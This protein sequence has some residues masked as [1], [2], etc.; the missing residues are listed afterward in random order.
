MKWQDF[1]RQAEAYFLKTGR[2][3]FKGFIAWAKKQDTNKNP[4]RYDDNGPES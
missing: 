1:I 4:H 2:T 3:D